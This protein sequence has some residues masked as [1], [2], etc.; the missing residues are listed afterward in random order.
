MSGKE[1]VPRD[2]IL[3][4]LTENESKLGEI[5]DDKQK[6]ANNEIIS[7]LQAIADE[8]YPN[9][10]LLILENIR[11]LLKVK[12]EPERFHYQLLKEMKVL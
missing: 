10:N 4:S 7:R 6:A 11:E 1:L 8:E 2:P 9:N 12:P 3:P 5:Q